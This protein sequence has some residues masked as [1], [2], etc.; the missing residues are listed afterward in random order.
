MTTCLG[1]KQLWGRIQKEEREVSRSHEC[2]LLQLD[3]LLVDVFSDS[4]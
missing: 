1:F 3:A 4:G 2:L